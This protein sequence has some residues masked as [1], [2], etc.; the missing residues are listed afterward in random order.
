MLREPVARSVSEYYYRRWGPRPKARMAAEAKMRGAQSELD[1][2]ACLA[3]PR[4]NR[5][6]GYNRV[7]ENE[8]TAIF[9]GFAPVCACVGALATRAC[10]PAEKQHAL[11]LAKHN[12]V[13][14]FAAIGL[15]ER[16]RESLA[17]FADVLPGLFGQRVA[18]L[19][20]SK[21]RVT[22]GV[23]TPP[24]E[25]TRAK[26]LAEVSLDAELYT[27]AAGLFEHRLGVCARRN[28]VP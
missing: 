26:I 12:L 21:Q 22:A 23:H 13:R 19:A 15:T 24:T 16:M 14:Q 7:D 4:A 28:P 5:T 10:L 3:L 1:V 17:H 8:Q 20:D 6:C 9:C 27:F 25:A 18:E 11:T 2:N